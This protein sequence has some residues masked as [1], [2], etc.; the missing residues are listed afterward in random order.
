MLLLL[1]SNHTMSTPD[2]RTP[3][4]SHPDRAAEHTCVWCSRPVCSECAVEDIVREQVFCSAGCQRA[5]ATIEAEHPRLTAEELLEG[6]EHP[7]AQGRKL[8]L[9]SFKPVVVEVGLPVTVAAV[10]MVVLSQWWSGLWSAGSFMVV[11]P[12]MVLMGAALALIGVVLSREHT[13]VAIDNPYVWTGQRFIPW[14]VTWMIV[15]TAVV[16]GYFLFIIPGIYLA[17]RLFWADEFAL[18]HRAGPLRA[19]AASWRLS[20]GAAGEIFRFQF[21]LSF[22]LMA[23]WIPA[24][25]VCVVVVNAL[26]TGFPA[27]ALHNIALAGLGSFVLV[28]VYAFSHACEIAYFYGLRAEAAG[29]L[30]EQE[31]HT[32]AGETLDRH[33][34]P[35]CPHCGAAYDPRDYREDAETIRCSACQGELEITRSRGRIVFSDS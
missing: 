2:T 29:L 18:I 10:A 26:E 21:V 8:W 1:H 15:S 11:F 19:V 30:D 6:L 34:H 16:F 13:G 12:V 3:C 31:D 23:V 22:A 25:I 24:V 14:T 17:L 35:L 32:Q 4:A 20:S 27:G 5:T 7:I 28:L 9:R 33:G